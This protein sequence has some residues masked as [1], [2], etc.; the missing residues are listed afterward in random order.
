MFKNHFRNSRKI[1]SVIWS[2]WGVSQ[3]MT[4]YV[5]HYRFVP[6]KMVAKPKWYG[7]MV[8]VVIPPQLPSRSCPWHTKRICMFTSTAV[9]LIQLWPL[10]VKKISP[11]LQTCF[12]TP[13]I[14]L[15][16]RLGCRTPMTPLASTT[17][18]DL[19]ARSPELASG[20][21]N[22]R[23]GAARGLMLTVAIA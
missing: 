3:F 13:W 11:L 23:P 7:N 21:P 9:L 22:G 17:D 1:R 12:P 16:A 5:F 6:T 14:T 10:P 8:N 18:S 19:Q 2:Y 15:G 4:Y 20:A